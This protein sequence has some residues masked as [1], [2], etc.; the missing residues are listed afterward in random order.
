MNTYSLQQII[1]LYKSGQINL[2]YSSLEQYIIHNPNDNKALEFLNTIKKNILKSNIEKINEAIDRFNY[3]EKEQRYSELLDAYLKIQKFA[4]DFKPL[5]SKINKVYKKVLADKNSKNIQ[6]YNQVVLIAKTKLANN[7]FQE[8]ISF[9]EKTLKNN[10]SNALISKLL[11]ETKRKIIDIKLKKN[12]KSLASTN[13]PKIY[14]FIKSLYDYESTYPRIHKMLLNYHYKLKEYY[15]N[16]KIIFE[17]DS[18]RQIKVLFNNKEYNKTLQT[19]KELLRT[20]TYNKTAIK[21]HKKALSK[22]EGQNF[23]NAYKLL[24]LETSKIETI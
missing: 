17:K 12:T 6:D 7:Q 3:L 9:I 23:E 13:I 18:E 22:I 2:A 10:P 11:I 21:Y 24:N 19:C 5:Q 16:Q 14:D 15:K 1:A 4:P 8:S 20:T